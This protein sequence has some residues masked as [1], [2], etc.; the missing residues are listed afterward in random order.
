MSL[1]IGWVLLSISC[2]LGAYVDVKN[3][4]LPNHIWWGWGCLTGI[5]T[6]YIA[7]RFK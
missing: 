1:I 7:L 4:K 6:M 2:A 3:I 5:F